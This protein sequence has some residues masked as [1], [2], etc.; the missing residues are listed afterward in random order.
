MSGELYEM[1]LN[2][3][4]IERLQ[5]KLRGGGEPPTI[6]GMEARVIKLEAIIPTLAT[7]EDMAKMEGSLKADLAR[8]AGDLRAEIHKAVNDQTWKLIGW[9]TGIGAALVGAA[10]FIARSV[11]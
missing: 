4:A 6:D 2:A 3:E 7:R 10:Y 1:K 8:T 9:S 11:H 5:A